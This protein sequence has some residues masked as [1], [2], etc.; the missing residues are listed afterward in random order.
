MIYPNSTLALLAQQHE[1]V[2]CFNYRKVL[3]HIRGHS[4]AAAGNRHDEEKQ[5]PAD[6]LSADS[7]LQETL[8]AVHSDALKI[9]RL[10]SCCFGRSH[11]ESESDQERGKWQT[12]AAETNSVANDI[13][14]NIADALT[15]APSARETATRV[16]AEAAE[17]SRTFNLLVESGG[18]DIGSSN[19]RS[20]SSKSPAHTGVVAIRIS[21]DTPLGL[22]IGDGGLVEKLTV[23][24]VVQQSGVMKGWRLTKIGQTI[25]RKKM[26]AA[27][28]KLKLKKAK[29]LSQEGTCRL[30]F[31]SGG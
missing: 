11:D 21:G 24:R 9:G 10:F 4:S 20:S 13:E 17:L 19:S 30:V 14:L 8:A 12:L 23:G 29:E 27:E 16:V 28:V 15:S 18:L 1:K 5:A 22:S 26:P 31:S 2:N 25:V 6:D 7:N 3:S